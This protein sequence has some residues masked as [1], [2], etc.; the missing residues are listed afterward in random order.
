MEVPPVRFPPRKMLVL[1]MQEGT[2]H[3][4]DLHGMSGLDPTPPGRL[5]LFFAPLH[6]AVSIPLA[7]PTPGG[8]QL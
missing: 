3:C 8:A 7:N 6:C 5:E 2:Q 1:D 4:W